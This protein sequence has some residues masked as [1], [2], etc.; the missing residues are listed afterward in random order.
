M[1]KPKKPEGP[2]ITK[3]VDLPHRPAED[4]RTPSAMD[5]IAVGGAKLRPDTVQSDGRR[6][7]GAFGAAQAAQINPSAFARWVDESRSAF[8]A[9]RKSADEWAPLID[10]FNSRPIHGHRRSEA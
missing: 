6:R 8:P 2:R 10:E 4:L 7:M 5:M 1:P 9:A 3:G